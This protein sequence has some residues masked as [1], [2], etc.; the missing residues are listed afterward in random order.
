MCAWPVAWGILLLVCGP[1]PA[2]AAAAETRTGHLLCQ[3]SLARGSKALSGW[4]C[5]ATGLAMGGWS[6]LCAAGPVSTECACVAVTCAPAAR[7][8]W[9]CPQVLWEGRLA[10][11]ARDALAR[12]APSS[13]A[14][15]WDSVLAV[16]CTSQ[17]CH[18]SQ[19][20]TAPESQSSWVPDGSRYVCRCGSL[21]DD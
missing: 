2:T 10:V 19:V 18:S 1:L 7:N 8:S 5:L 6:A 20:Q 9:S 21:V 15:W 17:V 3:S 14:P 13:E 4:W 12:P 11:T 16:A